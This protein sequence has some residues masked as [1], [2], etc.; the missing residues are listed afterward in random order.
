MAGQCMTQKEHRAE[1]RKPA[2]GK[3]KEAEIVLNEEHNGWGGDGTKE[4]ATNS[5][6]QLDR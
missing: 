5:G 6:S 1:A 3:A 2:T 4:E